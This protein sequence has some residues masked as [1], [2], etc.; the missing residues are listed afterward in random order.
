MSAAGKCACS[1]AGNRSPMKEIALPK[2]VETKPDN[3]RQ[4]VPDLAQSSESG[5]SCKIKRLDARKS[6]GRSST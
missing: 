3:C 6:R 2:E 5:R 4:I 1:E